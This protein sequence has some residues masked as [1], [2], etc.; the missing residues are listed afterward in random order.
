MRSLLNQTCPAVGR[1]MPVIRLN[2]V[3]LPAPLGPISAVTVPASTPKLTSS[4]AARPPNIFLMPRSSSS[5]RVGVMSR[6][7]KGLRVRWARPFARREE[8]A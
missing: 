5:G 3:D 6:R 4:T 8:A 7:G 1:K 2:S